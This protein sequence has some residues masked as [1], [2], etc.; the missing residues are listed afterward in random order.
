MNAGSL[1]ELRFSLP[2]DPFDWPTRQFLGT[3]GGFAVYVDD[4]V[5]EGEIRIE[6]RGKVVGKIVNIGEGE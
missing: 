4:S 3:V 6:D 1:H 5:P 2:A